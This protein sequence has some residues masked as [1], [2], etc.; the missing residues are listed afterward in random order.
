[1]TDRSARGIIP[2]PPAHRPPARGLRF[3][4]VDMLSSIAPLLATVVHAA[5]F[6]IDPAPADAT[7]TAA[8]STADAPDDAAPKDAAPLTHALSDGEE[9]SPLEAAYTEPAAQ[10]PKDKP[11]L[12]KWTGTISAGGTWSEGNTKRRTATALADAEYRREHDRINLKFLWTYADENHVLTDRRTFGSIKYDYF[13]GK[14]SY[15]FA[16]AEAGA[17]FTAHDKLRSAVG[18]GY[19]YQFMETKQLKLSGELGAVWFRE[20]FT[21]ADPTRDYTAGRAA[22]KA[23]WKPIDKFTLANEGEFYQGTDTWLNASA[24]ELTRGRYNFTDKFFIELAWIYTWNNAPATGA[25]R[26]DNLYTL[27]LG[28]AF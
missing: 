24:N 22:Y 25:K 10:D 20:E 23:E 21:T 9:A 6:A 12:N 8:S 18:G 7:P 27:N 26:V 13:L 11:V 17:N 28:W 14:K 19:G 5:P 15:L 2:R 1:L 16:I 3:V 4:E